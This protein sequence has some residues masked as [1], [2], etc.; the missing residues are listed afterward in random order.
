MF[1]K[2]TRPDG[3]DFY[4]GTIDYA[5]ALETGKRV[6]PREWTRQQVTI[7]GERFGEWT[8]CSPGVLHASDAPA[9]TLIGGGWPCRLFV[10]EGNPVIEAN[11]HKYGFR[12]LHVTAELP[13]WQALGP[14]GQQVVALIERARI[15]TATELDGLAAARVAAWAAAW[16]AVFGDVIGQY[17]FTQDHYDLLTG[18]WREAIGEPLTAKAGV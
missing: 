7:S 6:R 16:A 3:T 12:Q 2:A 18:P 4:T 15:L 13:A 10:V 17:G 1:Y 8:T 9:E 5:A 11:G 14:N